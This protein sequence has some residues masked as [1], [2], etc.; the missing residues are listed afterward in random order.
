MHSKNE[1]YEACPRKYRVSLLKHV[2]NKYSSLLCESLFA[3]K[4][5]AIQGGNFCLSFGFPSPAQQVF[6]FPS[7]AQQVLLQETSPRE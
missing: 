7:P 6:G 5:Q 4:L 2:L 3:L 1:Q